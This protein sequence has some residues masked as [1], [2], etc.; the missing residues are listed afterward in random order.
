MEGVLLGIGNPLLDISA[1]VPQEVLDKYGLKAGNATLAEPQHLPLYEELVKNYKVDFI[2]GGAAQN[3][4]RAAQWML[5]IPKATGYIGCIGA[6]EYGKTLKNAA[7]GDGVTTHYLVDPT[8]PTG[9]CAV[10]VRDKE[11]SL[12]ANL[13]AANNYKKTHFDSPE[14]QEVVQKAKYFYSTGFF[15]TVSP[16]TAIALGQYASQSNKTFLFNLSAP[17]LIQFFWDGKMQE[18]LKYADVV[19]AN[20]DEAATLGKKL[21]W[22][23][24]LKEIALKLAEYP[25]ANQ[26]RPRKVIFTQGA[27]E[28]IVCKDGKILTFKPIPL[29]AE[30][31]VDTNGAGDSFVGGF[32]SRFVQQKSLEEAIAAGH[33]CACECIKRSGCTFPPTPSFTFTQ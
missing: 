15:L 8:T 27:K 7:E 16:E 22:G 5:Q 18:V 14:I 17:F 31:I 11:R 1:H 9:T 19:F 21:G 3:A 25:K 10:C 26:S 12:V 2:A 24:D 20:E 32:L 30:E 33:Y 13:S 23:E 6:D 29:P 28:T 4:I